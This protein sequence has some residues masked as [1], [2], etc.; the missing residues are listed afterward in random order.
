MLWKKEVKDKIIV[1]ESGIKDWVYHV[2]VYC[3][4]NSSVGSHLNL[5]LPPLPC[6]KHNMFLWGALKDKASGW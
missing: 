3:F 4:G 1:P 2:P 5:L 6:D